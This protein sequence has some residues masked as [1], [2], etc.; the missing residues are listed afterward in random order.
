M[1]RLYWPLRYQA[2]SSTG[3]SGFPILPLRENPTHTKVKDKESKSR[4]ITKERKPKYRRKIK[5]EGSQKAAAYNR[6]STVHPKRSKWRPLQPYLHTMS[7]H[8]TV[9]YKQ[10]H[11]EKS[12][13]SS[14]DI[15]SERNFCAG[16]TIGSVMR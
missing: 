9:R 6:V 4:R 11:H 12:R 1:T 10:P 13:A 2:D 3:L 7:L 15:H 14:I 16:R 8:D 5:Y